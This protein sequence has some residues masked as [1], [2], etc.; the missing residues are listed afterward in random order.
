MSRTLP[1]ELEVLVYLRGEGSLLVYISRLMCIALDIAQCL[2][3]RR[4]GH[5]GGA[6]LE[7]SLL[8]AHCSPQSLCPLGLCLR[9]A[10]YIP[11]LGTQT[12]TWL[13]SLPLLVSSPQSHSQSGEREEKFLGWFPG[14]KKI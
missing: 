4:R 14:K 12:Q 2:Q 1:A 11:A 10:G 5:T 3:T 7:V 6:M 9:T 8:P 13:L